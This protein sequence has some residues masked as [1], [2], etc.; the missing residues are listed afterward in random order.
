LFA[1][2]TY[3]PVYLIAIGTHRLLQASFDVVMLQVV[4]QGLLAGAGS[5]YTYAKMVSLLGA[6]RAAVFP[7]LAP[8]LASLMAWPILGHVPDFAEAVGL[9]LS[10]FGLLITVTG[11]GRRSGQIAVDA[12]RKP[13]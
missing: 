11:G 13:A 1:V 2:V 9:G 10:I 7:A 5:L 12:G 4:V 6:A 8:G 3:L